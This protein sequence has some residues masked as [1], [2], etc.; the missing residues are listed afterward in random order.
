VLTASFILLARYMSTM[1]RIEETATVNWFVY[2]NSKKSFSKVFSLWSNPN[3]EPKLG[4][5]CIEEL[6]TVAGVGTGVCCRCEM[7]GVGG[8][9]SVVA[10]E[11]GVSAIV[12]IGTSTREV[13]SVLRLNIES[14]PI[15]G[16]GLSM[17]E[18]KLNDTEEL[19]C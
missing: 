19:C 4:R 14:I 15:S 2:L 1:P 5:S 3:K 12:V 9:G 16:L 13:D 7:K 17:L 11:R 18:T 10:D 8:G 6:G